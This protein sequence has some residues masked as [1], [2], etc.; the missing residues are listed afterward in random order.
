M[1]SADTLLKAQICT[2]LEKAQHLIN[3]QKRVDS[4]IDQALKHYIKVANLENQC[5]TLIVENASIATRLRFI[6]SELM[7]NLQAFPEFKSLQTLKYKVR[8]DNQ[9][10]EIKNTVNRKISDAS[11]ELIKQTAEHVKDENIKAAL[12]HLVS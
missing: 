9:A 4:V 2:L 12:K 10:K 5:L 3:L 1:N 7:S 8:P 6:E 11:A